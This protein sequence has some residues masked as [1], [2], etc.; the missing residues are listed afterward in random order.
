MKH[1][2]RKARS[3]GNKGHALSDID[4]VI[5]AGGLGTRLRSVVSD[6]PKV[7]ADMGGKPF[8]DLLVEY[9][10]GA[11]FGRIIL[12]V[13]H[14][15]DQVK[16]H[17]AGKGILFAEE[18][19]PLGTGGGV[20]NTERLVLSDPFFVMNGDSWLPAGIDLRALHD[21][22]RENDALVTLALARPRNEKDYGAV[23]M[24]KN[25][26]ISRFNE[27]LKEKGDHFLNAGVYVMNREIFSRMPSGSFSLEVDFFPKLVG[28]A[29]YGFPAEGEVV[30]IGTPERYE[31]AKKIFN[32]SLR[33]NPH[34]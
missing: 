20:K 4:V 15:K 19:E 18:E 3:G 10:R 33:A 22:H 28:D 32:S 13:G 24:D 1:T 27:K 26:R 9:L 30:D 12:S 29:F 16:D 17:Y 7:M 25:S 6:R 21:F 11:G 31:A 2:F 14:L 8:L 23:F 34:T 5:L